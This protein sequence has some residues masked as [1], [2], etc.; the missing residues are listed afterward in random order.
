MPLPARP[1]WKTLVLWSVPVL[2]AGAIGCAALTAAGGADPPGWLID[3]F[4]RASTY[5]STN[6]S[7]KAAI[8]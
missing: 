3:G 8:V 1:L 2:M 4:A 5:R 6:K 7:G